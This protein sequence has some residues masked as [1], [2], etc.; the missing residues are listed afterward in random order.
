[1]GHVGEDRGARIDITNSTFK[2][3]KFC[4]GLISYRK[5]HNVDIF[6]EGKYFKF[7]NYIV[8]EKNYTMSDNRE[9]AFIRIKDSTFENLAYQQGIKVLTNLNY[10]YYD[11]TT[12]CGSEAVEEYISCIF[13]PYD[14][15]GFVINA[16]GFP[17]GI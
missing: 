10:R 12:A 6:K 13:Q 4:K 9:S 2:H 16:S 7:S 8:R 5:L 15:R 3:S 14:H 1:M 11:Q 17:G